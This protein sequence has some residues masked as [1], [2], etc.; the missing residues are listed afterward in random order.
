MIETSLFNVRPSEA[1]DIIGMG[2]M[3]V[4]I[5]LYFLSCLRMLLCSK[6]EY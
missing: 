2:P 5:I 1:L 3:Y 4:W 6:G